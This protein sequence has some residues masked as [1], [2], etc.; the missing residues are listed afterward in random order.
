MDSKRS[1]VII[2]LATLGKRD[3]CRGRGL[4][5][6]DSWAQIA[7]F[8]LGYLAG[9]PPTHGSQVNDYNGSFHYPSPGF[10]F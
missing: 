1:I 7:I 9:V 5:V 2:D 8:L 4:A 6:P 3:S 10:H